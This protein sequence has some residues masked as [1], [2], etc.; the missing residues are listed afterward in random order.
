MRIQRS[1]QKERFPTMEKKYLTWTRYWMMISCI[2]Q[3]A[4]TLSLGMR[5]ALA[6]VGTKV[7]AVT[8]SLYP[9]LSRCALS[10]SARAYSAPTGSARL[11]FSVSLVH[12]NLASS[13]YFSGR[14]VHS[15]RSHRQRWF[16][17]GVQRHS[18]R[19]RCVGQIPLK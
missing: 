10:A 8:Q 19:N 11:L 7:V 17:E 15:E 14:W 13:V 12:P 2:S 1:L 9:G 4:Q 3:Q 16:W 5:E 18:P 6:G